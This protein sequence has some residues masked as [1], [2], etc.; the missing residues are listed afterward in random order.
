VADQGFAFGKPRPPRERAVEL[1]GDL[2][3]IYNAVNEECT[4][5]EVAANA[6]LSP[7]CVTSGL[8]ELE[9]EGLVAASNGRWR[10][11]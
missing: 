2:R 9:L 8:A 1:T 11:S 3:R 6:D 10:R 5:D 7:A 4:V